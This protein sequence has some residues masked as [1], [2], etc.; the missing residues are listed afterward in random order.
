MLIYHSP[1]APLHDPVLF[2]RLGVERP[3]PE[4]AERYRIL[5][6]A[7]E[8]GVHVLREAADHGLEPILAVHTRDYV[9]FLSRAWE[10]GASAAS[11]LAEINT[12]QFARVRPHKLPV[13]V[14]G[15]MGFYCSDTST[16]IRK[17][18]W[19]AVYGAAQTAV[20]GAEALLSGVD[21]AYALCR[22]PG[23][24]AHRGHASGFCFLNNAAIA[25]ARLRRKYA[26]V[27]ILDIDVHHGDGTQSIFYDRGDVLYV[28]VHAST[29]TYFPHFSGGADERGEG[30]GEGFNLNIPLEHGAGDGRYLAAIA[31]GMKAVQAFSPEALVVSLGLDAAADDPVGVLNVTEQGFVDAAR[32]IAAARAP[33]LLVQ[34]G[35]YPSA[36]LGRNLAAFLAS[37]EESRAPAPTPRSTRS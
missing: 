12:T 6:N 8:G 11:D 16:G 25:A 36:A 27:A 23:H 3:H 5:L 28:S 37:F 17:G 19:R 33:T 10:T 4:N 29:D 35:G 15:L 20:S 31:A 30:Q 34:E 21:A 2:Y 14:H 7:A 13:S 24:H 1:D 9:E 22:P 26:R 18:T 32:L